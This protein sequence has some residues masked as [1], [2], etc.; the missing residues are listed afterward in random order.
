MKTID[1]FATPDSMAAIAGKLKTVCSIACGRTKAMAGIRYWV[2]WIDHG[3]NDRHSTDLHDTQEAAL[4][5]VPT[6]R[7]YSESVKVYAT[8][9]EPMGGHGN[10]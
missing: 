5:A 10:A 7:A 4:K 1:M 2:E 6:W 9:D 8:Y 3:T